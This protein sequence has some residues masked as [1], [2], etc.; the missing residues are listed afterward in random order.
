MRENV[1]PSNFGSGFD[2]ATL[3]HAPM[4]ESVIPCHA[5]AGGGR[6]YVLE[7]SREP[8]DDAP[9]A[10]GAGDV[11]ELR[12]RDSGLLRARAPRIGCNLLDLE[13]TLEHCEHAPLQRVQI[14]DLRVEDAALHLALRPGLDSPP[15]HVSHS[16]REK[17]LC[18]HYPIRRRAGFRREEIAVPLHRERV[19]NLER[20]PEAIHGPRGFRVRRSDYDMP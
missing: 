5:L 4:K 1:V 11:D 15:P 17:P 3:G 9:G 7:K 16:E 18:R 14:H 2:F 6:L 19:W 10:Q 13:L 12:Q 20:R 8:A